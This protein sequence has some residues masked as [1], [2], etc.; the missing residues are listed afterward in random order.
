M[1][2]AT[3]EALKRVAEND[4]SYDDFEYVRMPVECHHLFLSFFLHFSLHSVSLSFPS[5]S[6]ILREEELGDDG[7][8]AL[9]EALKTNTRWEML[10]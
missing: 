4:P 1:K 5:L 9:A 7:A 6:A 2:E 10:L 3:R 8:V